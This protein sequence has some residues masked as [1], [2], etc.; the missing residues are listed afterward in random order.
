MA[1]LWGPING[2]FWSTPPVAPDEGWAYWPAIAVLVV[3]AIASV[4]V[5]RCIRAKRQLPGWHLRQHMTEIGGALTLVYLVGITALTWG[6]IG[7]L[8]A[9]PL[10]EVGDFLAGAF[11]PVA[12]LWLVLGFLQ[13]GD[14]LRM[15]TEALKD[16]AVQLAHSVQHQLD[17]AEAT[18]KQSEVE[19]TKLQMEQDKLDKALRANFSIHVISSGN[20]PEAM[21]MNKIRI[22]NEGAKVS[23]LA[24]SF[25]PPIH[26]AHIPKLRD[27]GVK[28]HQ[29]FK[30]V[31]NHLSCSE[32]GVAQISYLDTNGTGRHQ[33]FSYTF[34][35]ASA[36]FSFKRIFDE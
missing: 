13:Q 14:E 16:Q 28:G 11:G 25:D 18:K 26:G 8:G 9:M 12:F 1:D 30:F 29:E 15:S 2:V 3:A 7:T 19:L 6:R 31:F 27:L 22:W 17:L 32:E 4:V 35:Y 36:R 23:D 5:G 20:E 10:N 33:S 21:T 24:L 34:D